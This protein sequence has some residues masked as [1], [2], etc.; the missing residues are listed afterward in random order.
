MGREYKVSKN[1]FWLR[2]LEAKDVKKV[3]GKKVQDEKPAAK[4]KVSRKKSKEESGE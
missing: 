1:Q 4:K 2:R 3:S